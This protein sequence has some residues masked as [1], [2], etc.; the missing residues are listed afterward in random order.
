MCAVT[1]GLPVSSL[2]GHGQLHRRTFVNEP[3]RSQ[4]GSQTL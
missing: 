4:V 1:H 2:T 3:T